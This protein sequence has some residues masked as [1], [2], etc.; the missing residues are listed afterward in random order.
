MILNVKIAYLSLVNDS[1]KQE[2]FEEIQSIIDKTID[3]LS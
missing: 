1:K 2:V 3:G